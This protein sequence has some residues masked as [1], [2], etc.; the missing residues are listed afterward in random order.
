MNPAEQTTDEA[1]E[2]SRDLSFSAVELKE[3][4]AL[5][6][7]VRLDLAPRTTVLVGKNGAGKSLLLE[8]MQ[9]AI[10]AAAGFGQSADLDP[11]HFACEVDVRRLRPAEKVFTLR[12]EC[13][14]RLREEEQENAEAAALPITADADLKVEEHCWIP[15]GENPLL[16]RVDDGVITYNNGERGEMSTGRTLVNWTISR[17]GR[18]TFLLPVLARPL[19]DLFSHVTRVSAGIPRGDGEREELALP[20]PEPNRSRHSVEARRIRWLAYTL[21]RWH[22]NEHEQFDEFVALSRRIGLLA[23]VKVKLYRDPDAN[24]TA[25]S[26]D[27]AS[28]LVDGTDFGLLSDG[29]LRVIEILVWLIFPTMKLL[30]IEEPETAVHPGLLAKLL[31]EIDAYSGDRQIVLSTQSPHVVS[32]ADPRAIRL[33]ERRAGKTEVRSLREDEIGRVSAYLH[34]EGT[35]GDFVYSGALD[36]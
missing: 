35:L 31:A 13:H 9:A 4:A 6:G 19:L 15:G 7:D 14:W 1:G 17:R 32:W 34:D 22:Q 28:V 3:S 2:Q 16:W 23:E 33:V 10:Q 8:K 29:T 36:G 20:Y 26:R 18:G 21:V 24:R 30:L 25:R 11:A 12:Y 27:F 5:G